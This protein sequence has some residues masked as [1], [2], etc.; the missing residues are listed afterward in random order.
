M[1]KLSLLEVLGVFVV[2][3][4]I[5]SFLADY[6][7]L[8]SMGD[9]GLLVTFTGIVFLP[10]FIGALVFPA[11]R[12]VG[13]IMVPSASAVLPSEFPE[14]TYSR[15]YVWSY[16]ILLVLILYLGV[17]FFTEYEFTPNPFWLIFDLPKPG[18]LNFF[19]SSDIGVLFLL[20]LLIPIFIW[21]RGNIKG[22]PTLI[23]R[24]AFRLLPA[25]G[26]IVLVLL[27][28]GGFFLWREEKEGREKS[29]PAGK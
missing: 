24:Q 16:W 18:T 4:A 9:L 1:R 2:A 22:G 5:F 28:V 19:N 27:P 7:G 25:L 14:K 3:G 23:S 13:K 11:A 6:F 8:I 21:V 26:L 12:T 15:L 17:G 20:G 29:H 10:F